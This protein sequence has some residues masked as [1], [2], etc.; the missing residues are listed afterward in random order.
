VRLAA[1]VEFKPDL[2][3]FLPVTLDWAGNGDVS[4]RPNPTNT[5][6][7][8]VSLGGTDGFVELPRGIAHFP[9]GYAAR[10]FSW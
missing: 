9:A 3:Y 7:D 2:T 4:A 1:P 5:S 10:F 6:G 8:F